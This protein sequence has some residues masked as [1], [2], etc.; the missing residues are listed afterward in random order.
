MSESRKTALIV[1]VGPN[2]GAALG[3]K[4][5]K[6]YNVLMVARS[7]DTTSALAQK[8]PYAAAYQC[9]IS[10][11]AA[12]SVLLDRITD[13]HGIPDV[14]IFNAE[15]GEM[16]GYTGLSLA[17]FENSFAIIVTPILMM[18]QKW[19][20]QIESSKRTFKMIVN[21]S[22]VAYTTN[23]EF[24]GMGPARWAQRQLVESL[25]RSTEGQ[26]IS[27]SILS[28]DGPIDSAAMR[29]L[30]PDLSD[31]SFIQPDAIADRIIDMLAPADPGLFHVIQAADH[32]GVGS[33][34]GRDALLEMPVNASV[35]RREV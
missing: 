1:G 25:S 21:S 8:L 2:T 14:V 18:A 5:G 13:E 23:P 22:P 15:G 16:G 26:S 9:D 28:I 3:R 30:L 20:T 34:Q 7:L 6:D 27:L 31:D 4:L 33:Q 12:F 32:I 17:T 29:K 24:A 11:S 19:F 35:A 10:Q